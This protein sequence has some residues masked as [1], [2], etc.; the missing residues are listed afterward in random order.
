ME[1]RPGEDAFL[2]ADGQN[3]FSEISKAL[4]F[5]TPGALLIAILS[6]AI[7]L[8]WDLLLIKKHKIFQVIQGP[9]V[10]VLLGIVINIM[11][12]NQVLPF[13]L[14]EKQIVSVPVPDSISNF[15]QQFTFPDFSVITNLEVWKIAVV[16]A[17]VA[18]L[19]TLL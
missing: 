15:F 10:V 17:V 11:Y 5:I 19:E 8:L 6:I 1:G 3:T 18:S 7:L 12:Q 13:G 2:Q 4:D 9:I 16:I 14:D